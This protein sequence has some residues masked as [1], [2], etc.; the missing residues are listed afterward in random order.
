MKG[1]RTGVWKAANGAPRDELEEACRVLDFPHRRMPDDR[2]PLCLTSPESVNA[3]GA[4]ATCANELHVPFLEIVRQLHMQPDV[5][6]A[7]LAAVAL[8]LPSSEAASCIVA[9]ALA[10]RSRGTRSAV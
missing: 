9:P 2:P 3:I 1:V 8:G 4:L 5:I 6:V 10:R 7:F